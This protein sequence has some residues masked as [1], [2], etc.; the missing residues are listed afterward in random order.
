MV[1]DGIIEQ[2]NSLPEQM[3]AVFRSF[4]ITSAAISVICALI[5]RKIRTC[6]KFRK[7]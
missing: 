3:N 2:G 5:Q 1:S 4:L 6:M 7:W